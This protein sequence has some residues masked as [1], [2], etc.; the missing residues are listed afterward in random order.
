VTSQAY[1]GDLRSAV[2]GA[3]SGLAAADTLCQ[4]NADATM[5]GG[6]FKAYLAGDSRGPA[7]ALADVG[8]WFSVTTTGQADP[9][10]KVFNNRA[11]LSTDPVSIKFFDEHGSDNG[12][13]FWK[14]WTGA[15]GSNV[16]SAATALD[17]GSNCSNW[18]S[19][20][21]NTTGVS[22]ES[23]LSQGIWRETLPLPNCSEQLHLYCF[24]Q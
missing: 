16:A 6:T 24:E 23:G 19:S 12:G 13:R 18:T 21:A 11:N 1:T 8:P 14:V 10:A 3:V 5:L 7:D 2:S 22:G 4:L 20:V 9:D 15:K 17:R